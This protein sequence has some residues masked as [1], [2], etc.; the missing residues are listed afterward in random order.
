MIT[1]R[2]PGQQWSDLYQLLQPPYTR[3]L[4]ENILDAPLP[5]SK[6]QA[7]LLL[8]QWP[9]PCE[10]QSRDPSW[11]Y[12]GIVI[13]AARSMS[14]DRQQTIPSLRSLG[15]ASGSIRA[16][17]NTWLGTFCVATSLSLHLGLPPPIDSDLDFNSIHAFLRRNTVTPTFAMQVRVQLIVAKFTSL[18]NHDIGDT[19]SSSFMRLLD[20]ELEALR[21]E[22]S[23]EDEQMRSIELSILSAKMHLYALVIT[24][25]PGNSASRQIMMRTARDVALRIIHLSTVAMRNSPLGQ[26]D[27]TIIRKTRC[28]PKNHH[29]CTAFATIFLLKFFYRRG[30]DGPDEKQAVANHIAM[31]QTLF[32]ACSTEPRDEWSRTAKVFET[33]GAEHS[34]QPSSSKLRLTHRMGVSILFDAV[35]SAS[36]A[37]GRPVEIQDEDTP[38]DTSPATTG[39]PGS[40]GPE[41]SLNDVPD[42]VPPEPGIDF[43]PG[44]W[45]DPYMSLLSFD[46]PSLEAEYSDSWPSA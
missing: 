33:L 16:R 8:C 2:L 29:R 40:T 41:L 28:L 30:A 3:M 31:G 5:L 10:T 13:Q 21:T 18:L 25:D 22:L 15:V 19:A 24:K 23:L 1:C 44:F 36:E 12:C 34:T 39:D 43:L 45:N 38:Q 6:I 11:L 4:Q 7:I 32:N 14:L 26:G 27:E 17:I 35:S 42:F 20:S 46:P 37:R 9:L